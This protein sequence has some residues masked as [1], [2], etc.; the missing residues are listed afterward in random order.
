MIKRLIAL[1]LCWARAY[2]RA[3]TKDGV[4][5]YAPPLVMSAA[6]PIWRVAPPPRIREVEAAA[7]VAAHVTDPQVVA[8]RRASLR[9]IVG[10]QSVT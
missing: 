8:A 2:A 4:W 6:N 9:L 7:P 3:I 5:V 1:L 10:S